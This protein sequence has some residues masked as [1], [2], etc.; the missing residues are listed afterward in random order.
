MSLSLINTPD[1]Q[2][3]I[4]TLQRALREQTQRNAELEAELTQEKNKSLSVQIGVKEL[5]SIL[6]PLYSAIG[7]IFGHMEA[8]GVAGESS[9]QVNDSTRKVWDSWKQ[10]LSGLNAKAIDVL[11]LHGPMNQAQLRIQL[12]CATRSVT[13]V[14]G[15]LNKAGLIDKSGGKISLKPLSK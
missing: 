14:V 2:T 6:S 7:V 8:M 11:L 15:A 1:Y 3:Q 5:R 12:G 10:K 13:N 4:S 9:A